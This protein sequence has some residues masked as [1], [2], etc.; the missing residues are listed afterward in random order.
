MAKKSSLSIG[1]LLLQIA[2]GVMLVIGGIWALIGGG[3]FGA[4]AFRSIFKGD[5]RKILIIFYG[6]IELI[7]GLFILLELFLGDLLGK[8]L[9]ICILI[10][11]IIWIIAIVLSDF[12]NGNFLRGG[13]LPWAWDFA[14]HLLVLGGFLCIK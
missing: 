11:A 5:A 12:L 6:I 2:L 8:F 13:F 7:A 1:R 14:T 9:N 4:E 3:D 10:I